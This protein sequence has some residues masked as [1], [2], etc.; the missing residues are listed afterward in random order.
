MLHRVIVR[1]LLHYIKDHQVAI[2]KTESSVKQRK[3]FKHVIYQTLP[4]G[5][6]QDEWINSWDTRGSGNITENLQK[7]E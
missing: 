6:Q 1:K 3:L 5:N 4:N 7:K 2:A